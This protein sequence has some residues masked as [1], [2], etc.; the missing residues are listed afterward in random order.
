MVKKWEVRIQR[1]DP[2]KMGANVPWM[3][4]STHYFDVE[5]EATDFFDNW[6]PSTR[7]PKFRLQLV[8][9]SERVDR[10]RETIPLNRTKLPKL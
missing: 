4:H 5:L 1:Q 6:K 2:S 7:L 8:C 10:I 9:V 3:Q